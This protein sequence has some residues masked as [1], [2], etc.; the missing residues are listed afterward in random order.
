M[1]LTKR[2]APDHLRPLLPLLDSPEFSREV[3][4]QT[5]VFII[6]NAI[7]A[8]TLRGW[9][10]AWQKFAADL[11]VAGGRQVNRFNP[12]AVDETPPPPLADMHK[13]PALLDII[14]QAF[15]PDIALYNQRFVVKDELSRTP[16]FTHQ[17]YCY[18]RGWPNKASAFVPL[19]PMTPQNGGMSFYPGTHHFGYLGDAGE[20]DLAVL[21][22]DWPEIAPSV[23]PGDLVLMNSCTWHGSGPHISGPDRVLADIIYQPADDPSGVALLR[24]EWRTGVFLNQLPRN[25]FVRSRASRLTDLQKKVD[26]FEAQGHLVTNAV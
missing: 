5:G 16:V 10:S 4:V 15:G 14:E 18:H 1:Q 3:F 22:P 26:Q 8:E 19:S 24:G 7:P 6:R 11:K 9:Q 13:H 12:V 21:G 17:D 2:I 25:L 23:N 20:L